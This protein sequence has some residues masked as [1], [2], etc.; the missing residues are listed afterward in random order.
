MDC[1]V[2]LFAPDGKSKNCSLKLVN[3]YESQLRSSVLYFTQLVSSNANERYE[4]A[5]ES[6]SHVRE[7]KS[8]TC[9]S[10][11]TAT[12]IRKIFSGR[13]KYDEILAGNHRGNVTK[14]IHGKGA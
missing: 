3:T 8:H 12:S 9:L 2:L 4:M 6:G 11:P 10:S 5:M 13:I 1:V 7:A 14:Q